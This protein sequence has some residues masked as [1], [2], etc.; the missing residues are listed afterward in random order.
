LPRDTYSVR[1]EPVD[2]RLDA[3]WESDPT[4]NYR[5]IFWVSE[6]DASEY[7]LEA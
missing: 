6:T 2:P 7:D 5:V 4:I 1:A 3:E